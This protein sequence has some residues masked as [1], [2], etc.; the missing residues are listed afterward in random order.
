MSHSHFNINERESILE[1]LA[2]GLS[3]TKIAEKIGKHKSSVGRE[4]KRNSINGKYSPHGA[5]ELY[6][7]RKKECGAKRKLENSILVLDIQEKLGLGWTPEQI[8]GRAN[9]EGLLP[10]DLHYCDLTCFFI[11]H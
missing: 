7:Q 1:Y 6:S 3:R 8:S 10:K 9:L 11:H 4:I 2:L 5:Q